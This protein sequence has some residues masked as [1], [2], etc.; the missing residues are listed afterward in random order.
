MHASLSYLT[1]MKPINE[2][3]TRIWQ[4]L[5]LECE[6]VL[7]E[8][9]IQEDLAPH[10]LRYVDSKKRSKGH[11]KRIMYILRILGPEQVAK[12]GKSDQTGILREIADNPSQSAD[13]R[14]RLPL[15]KAMREFL[16]EEG[17]SRVADITAYLEAKG[18]ANLSRQII[19]SAIRRHAET[20]GVRTRK[21]ER[22][23]FLKETE[24]S[25]SD[26]D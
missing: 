5:I 11:W 26:D 3:D 9:K 21:R 12:I 8:R 16:S 6:E 2:T 17:E 1:G 22:L 18:Y 4:R 14:V 15:W 10:H 7:S 25:Q 20:F 23:V 13:A 19:E 24:E